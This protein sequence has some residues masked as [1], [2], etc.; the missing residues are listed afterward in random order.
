LIALQKSL[1]RRASLYGLFRWLRQPEATPDYSLARR[2]VL[3]I[4]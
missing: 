3:R 4:D 2:L 1:D